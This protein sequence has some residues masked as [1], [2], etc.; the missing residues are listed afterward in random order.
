MEKKF[1]HM[2]FEVMQPKIKTTGNSSTWMNHTGSVVVECYGPDQLI[3]SFISEFRGGEEGLK[4]GKGL[5]TLSPEKRGVI[6]EGMAY[7]RGAGGE[8]LIEN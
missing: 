2:K 4:G 6:R 1:R 3:Q 7:L 5:I 8:V